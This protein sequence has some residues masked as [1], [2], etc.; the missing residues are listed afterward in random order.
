MKKI[1]VMMI[2][3][4]VLLAGCAGKA[5]EVK[6][7]QVD[8]GGSYYEISVDQLSQMMENKDFTLVNVHIPYEGDI[9]N[10]DVSIAYNEIEL[11]LDQLPADQS[12]K[13]VLYC[14]SDSMSG[15]AAKVLAGLGYTN[16][17]DVD[18]G[19][20]AWKAAGYPFNE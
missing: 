14:R 10:T 7:I 6:T 20:N 5:E 17:Y 18:G 1:F 2:I 4:L 3:G 15:I 9:P 12:A 8:G 13:I 11:H 19:F 16:V